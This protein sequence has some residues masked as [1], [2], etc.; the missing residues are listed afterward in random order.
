MVLRKPS[1]A[2]KK[3]RVSAEKTPVAEEAVPEVATATPAVV[4]APVL[5]E[6]QRYTKM[7]YSKTGAYG[8][9]QIYE[10]KRQVFQIRPGKLNA[11]L[12]LELAS[13]VVAKLN[14]G[15][16]TAKVQLWAKE[17]T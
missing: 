14:A 17:Q 13:T 11:K 1:A 8:F 10:P 12:M 3:Q 2:T 4:A 6:Q 16:D 15:E 7:H 9:R 5:V